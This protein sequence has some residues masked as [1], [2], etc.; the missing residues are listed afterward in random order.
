MS[1]TS[2]DARRRGPSVAIV[3]GLLA[4]IAASAALYVAFPSLRYSLIL[5]MPSDLMLI[6]ACA[7]A[8][9]AAVRTSG[10]ERTF[11]ALLVAAIAPQIVAEFLVVVPAAFGVSMVDSVT[12]SSLA[13]LLSL[14]A[15][16]FLFALLFAMMPAAGAPALDRTRAAIDVVILILLGTV[17]ALIF[18][19]APLM[20]RFGTPPDA[21]LLA[22]TRLVVGGAL[23][24]GVALNVYGFPGR[25]WPSWDR[26]V[27]LGLTVIG[28]TLLT[29]PAW[30][31]GTVTAG[32]TW[33]DFLF[34]AGLTAASYFMAV[35]GIMRI[36]SPGET[37]QRPRPDL[38]S[39]GTGIWVVALVPAAEVAALVL[40][41]IVGWSDALVASSGTVLIVTAIAI[42]LIALRT[43]LLRAVMA[44]SASQS[45]VDMVTGAYT[46]AERD[47]VAGKQ[48]A[49]A[50][51]SGER[52]S[53]VEVDID[54][55]GR[56]ND[57][58]GHLGGD[59]LLRH[60]AD[61]IEDA[62]PRDALVFRSGSDSFTIS[63][64]RADR[65]AAAEVAA[66]VVAALADLADHVTGPV[67]ASAGVAELGET[68]DSAV[69]LEA[70]AV[71]ALLDARSVG[72]G[73]VVVWT[74][75]GVGEP[76]E[77]RDYS[78]L[79]NQLAAVVES[80]SEFDAGHGARVSDLGAR[81]ALV[82][83]M[84]PADIEPMRQ[85][86]RLHDLGKIGVSDR[87]LD[88]PGDLS[89]DEEATVREHPALGSRLLASAV[90][91]RILPWI[92]HHHERWDGAGYPS[93]IG[94][95]DLPLGSRVL[96]LADA[97]DNMLV[98]QPTRRALTFEE[99]VDR[100]VGERGAAFDPLLVD[101][102]LAEVVW[103]D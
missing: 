47:V 79:V 87:I 48:V 92:L 57:R 70:E 51:A 18:A 82:A 78:G 54:S 31:L 66:E 90:D 41:F 32:L 46:A 9:I 68:T 56:V 72:Q 21:Q 61:A 102:F 100:L 6:F 84:Q 50:R 26:Y 3:A 45:V 7:T 35:G 25:F 52:L 88:K 76:A 43:A 98:K 22:A 8:L 58:I 74:P 86:G 99:A 17:A 13:G 85:A 96:A 10:R 62:A 16:A 19:T 36:T 69:D 63:L 59:A 49:F 83:G 38:T 23:L 34:G 71:S 103:P 33:P 60:A 53:L 29:W 44:E 5:N 24:G 42:P 37:L 39:T 73:S 81:L 40:A 12:A 91:Q 55:F 27:A 11:W 2:A 20:A 65:T 14:T 30:Y 80:R 93:G 89:A 75:E 15:T 101:V 64:P 95:E 1:A 97:W 28:V 77:R 67:S 4:L 94:G